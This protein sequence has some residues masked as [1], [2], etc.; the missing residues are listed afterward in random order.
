MASPYREYLDAKDRRLELTIGPIKDLKN[1]DTRK[2]PKQ[3]KKE[4]LEVRAQIQ[5]A[6]ENALMDCA[7]GNAPVPPEMAAELA[8][9][10]RD[11]VNGVTNELLVPTP[12]GRGEIGRTQ[13]ERSCIEDA[14]RYRWAVDMEYIND[15]HPIKTILD[16]FGGD[17]PM[18]GGISRR[19][20]QKWM[21]DKKFENIT[22]TEVTAKSLLKLLNFSGAHYQQ[23]FSKKARNED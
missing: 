2:L 8:F 19:T 17:D 9:A 7:R 3:K 14:V 21:I 6:M 20:V 13:T 18:K 10:M 4:M 11:V 15:R 1:P 23:N 16:A 5:V 12:K 22:T